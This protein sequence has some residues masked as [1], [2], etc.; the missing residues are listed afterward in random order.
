MVNKY[1]WSRH[2]DDEIW[3]GGPCDP[4]KECVE[5]A[6]AEGY[7]LSDTFAIGLIENYS[8]DI[9]FADM[10][11][12]RLQEDA[13]DVVGEVSDGWLDY[14][15][16]DD[17]THLDNKLRQVVNDWLKEIKEEPTFYTIAPCSECT[18][19]EALAEHH[20]RVKSTPKGGKY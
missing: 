17:I 2:S 10:I 8:I 16:R 13:Y 20:E 19:E 11:I 15:N 6:I 5:E 4:I 9:D 1:A 14:V 3:H 7:E 18:L 12:E